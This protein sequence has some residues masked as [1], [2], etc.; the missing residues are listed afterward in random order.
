M[1]ILIKYLVIVILILQQRAWA[2]QPSPIGI[3]FNPRV[4]TFAI[5]GVGGGNLYEFS[6]SNNSTSGQMAIDWN[7]ALSNGLTKRT[8]KEKLQTLTTIFKYNPLFTSKLCL[9]GFD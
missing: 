3:I 8:R 2:Q 5:S 1:K 9:W 7:V 4:N 6:A